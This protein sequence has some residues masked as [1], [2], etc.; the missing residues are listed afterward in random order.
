VV[1]EQVELKIFAAD[2]ELNL[3]SNEGE[4]GAE[5]D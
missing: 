4:A 5:F 1:K 2:F 3:A